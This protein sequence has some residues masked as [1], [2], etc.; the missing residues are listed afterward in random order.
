MSSSGSLLMKAIFHYFSL[1]FGIIFDS[2]GPSFG[3]EAGGLGDRAELRQRLELRK[4]RWARSPNN[5]RRPREGRI[6]ES[7]FKAKK[8]Y[9]ERERERERE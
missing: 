3:L 7:F 4:P 2:G 5:G 9:T 8:R 6:R 1:K